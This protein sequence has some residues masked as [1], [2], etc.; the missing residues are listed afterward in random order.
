MVKLLHILYFLVSSRM[1]I[2]LTLKGCLAADREGRRGRREAAALCKTELGLLLLGEGES[3]A[4]RASV[5]VI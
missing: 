1:P 5:V 2:L 3:E 4:R